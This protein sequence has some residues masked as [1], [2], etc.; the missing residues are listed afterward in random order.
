[1]SSQWKNRKS[2]EMPE[3][4]GKCGKL[5][6]AVAKVDVFFFFMSYVYYYELWTPDYF[7]ECLYLIIFY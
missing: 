5:L 2:V 7:L 3:T 6:L 4:I 1:M